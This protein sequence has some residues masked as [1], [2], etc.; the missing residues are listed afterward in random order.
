MP[1]QVDKGGIFSLSSILVW[2]LGVIPVPLL[3]Y[4]FPPLEGM[5]LFGLTG[6]EALGRLGR[7]VIGGFY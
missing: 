7:K 6:G 4:F 5:V 2:R 3:S 1:Q